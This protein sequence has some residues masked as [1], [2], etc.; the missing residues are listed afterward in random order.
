MSMPKL[1]MKIAE[2][3]TTTVHAKDASQAVQNERGRTKSMLGFSLF[4]AR[5][6]KI[7]PPTLTPPENRHNLH[8]TINK[9]IQQ[10][11]YLGV[12]DSKFER[13]KERETQLQAQLLSSRLPC[14]I[15]SSPLQ[16]NNSSTTSPTCAN[17]KSFP[18]PKHNQITAKPKTDETIGHCT[19]LVTTARAHNHLKSRK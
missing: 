2:A 4:P 1:S 7:Q 8:P 11:T 5:V 14:P 3:P 19:E 16:R 15:H 10:L 6:P 12:G 9:N 17:D 13:R 18:Q